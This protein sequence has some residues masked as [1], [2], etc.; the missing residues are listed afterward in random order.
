M[1]TNTKLQISSLSAKFS[2]KGQNFGSEL[3]FPS[4]H[5][6][7]HALVSISSQ[8]ENLVK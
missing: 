1:S 6:D 8:D 5:R 2:I 4:N 3:I 7:Y